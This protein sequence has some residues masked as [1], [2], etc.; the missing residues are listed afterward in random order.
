MCY[1]KITVIPEA[2][3]V[4][5]KSY[6]NQA[7]V[8]FITD[9]NIICFLSDSRRE[10]RLFEMLDI[11]WIQKQIKRSRRKCSFKYKSN[12]IN[13]L[14]CAGQYSSDVL[15]CFC[16]LNTHLLN[17]S[18]NKCLKFRW[19]FGIHPKFNSPIRTGSPKSSLLLT[20]F[21]LRNWRPKVV[22]ADTVPGDP[23]FIIIQRNW[24]SK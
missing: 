3:V 21:S 20:P 1:S 6:I 10:R 15:P 13:S 2:K 9:M 22:T 17:S 4:V 23:E 18:T 12:R 11:C 19:F 7:S 5:M 24:S 14:T 16:Y 8:F